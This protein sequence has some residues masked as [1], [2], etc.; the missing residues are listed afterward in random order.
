[1]THPIP[2]FV[3]LVVSLSLSA[4][5]FAQE[6]ADS[7][8]ALVRDTPR[9]STLAE[10]LEDTGVMASLEKPTR[11]TFF[12]PSDAA[13]ER[14]GEEAVAALLR[15]RG[16]LDVIIRHHV[17]YGAAPLSALRRMDAL[18]T[19]EGTRLNVRDTGEVVRISG[20]RIQGEEIRAGNGVVYVID[21]LLLPEASRVVKDLLAGPQSN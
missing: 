11:I 3:A 19:L 1:M 2:R 14:L 6:P 16:A 17:T 4:G 13:F 10:L 12:A 7:I 5:A 15:D 18:T 9:L 8:A 20:V 21:R